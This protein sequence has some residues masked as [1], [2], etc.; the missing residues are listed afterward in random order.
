MASHADA[1][2]FMAILENV[3]LADALLSDYLIS[4]VQQ[5][6]ADEVVHN[7]SIH[8]PKGAVLGR[9]LLENR[10]SILLL[11]AEKNHQSPCFESNGT[12]MRQLQQCQCIRRHPGYAQT[13]G[14][15]H[16]MFAAVD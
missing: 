13:A 4:R 16:G 1:G 3:Q 11:K 10:G 6:E 14:Y 8:A 12:L 15:F 7:P 2:E 5:L 9:P